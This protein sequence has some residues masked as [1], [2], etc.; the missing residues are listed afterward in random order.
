MTGIQGCIVALA[1]LVLVGCGPKEDQFVDSKGAA[2]RQAR[3]ELL[4]DVREADDYKEFH[5]PNSTNIPFGRLESRLAELEPYKAK[6]IM[7]ID[8]SGLRSPRAWE[9]LK[10]AGFSQVSVVTGGIAEWRKAGLPVQT[11]EMQLEQER[12]QR[13][14]EQ[15]EEEE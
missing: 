2:E 9:Q 1:A 14:Q 11:L 13:E 4:L 3:G 5:V 12:L 6:P 10:K 8:H 7:V 15:M